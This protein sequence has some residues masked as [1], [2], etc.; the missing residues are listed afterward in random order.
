MTDWL[1]SVTLRRTQVALHS[2]I[3]LVIVVAHSRSTEEQTIDLLTYR[4]L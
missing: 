2:S 1:E 3:V 4:D